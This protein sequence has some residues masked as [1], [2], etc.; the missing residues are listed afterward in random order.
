MM[1]GHQADTCPPFDRSSGNVF[2]IVEAIEKY[3][4]I[5]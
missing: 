1:H 3:R 5:T 2:E 4:L